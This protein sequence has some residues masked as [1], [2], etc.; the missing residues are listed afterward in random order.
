[1]YYSV[2]TLP[3]SAISSSFQNSQ[4]LPTA[5]YRY[6]KAASLISIEFK[7]LFANGNWQY[8]YR[9]TFNYSA[10]RCTTEVHASYSNGLWNDYLKIRY[11]YS[12]GLIDTVYWYWLESGI[13]VLREKHC[14]K[15]NINGFEI[16]QKWITTDDNILW[17]NT[18]LYTYQ[19]DS[20]GTTL[21][22]TW[23]QWLN[24]GWQNSLKAIY[25]YTILRV[26]PYAR[27][28]SAPKDN[29]YY[30]EAI[31][32][33]NGRAINVASNIA[34]SYYARKQVTNNKSV[35]KLFVKTNQ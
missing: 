34:N 15:C 2:D 25:S 26:H 13:W 6:L 33:I 10:S 5:R 29:T 35:F 4:W 3:D 28:K 17:L 20:S 27:R 24:N 21:V 18:A 1:M 16:E 12:A 22:E 11:S 19:V 31:Y 30:S 23:Q 7:D 32:S 14:S 9:T 8:K